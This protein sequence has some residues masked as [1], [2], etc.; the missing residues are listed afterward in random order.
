M[1]QIPDFLDEIATRVA[2]ADQGWAIIEVSPE[3]FSA[4]ANEL[5]EELRWQDEVGEHVP[6]RVKM[7]IEGGHALTDWLTEGTPA[8]IAIVM[9]TTEEL[10][11]TIACLDADRNRLLYGPRVIIV[12][13]P[14]GGRVVSSAQNLWSWVGGRYW[15][16]VSGIPTVD[17]DARLQ[18]FR[19]FTGFSDADIVTAAENGSL[20]PDPIFAEWLALI[21][22][23]ELI[24]P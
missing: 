5:A 3:S 17:T 20:N 19:E 14:G 24:G 1:T 23:G 8:S 10:A 4:I 6:V 11:N 13:Q 7:G 21:G 12:T 15:P 16:H 9:L 22:R 2:M 18:G